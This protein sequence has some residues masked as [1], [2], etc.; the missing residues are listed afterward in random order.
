MKKNYLF[1]LVTLFL[2]LVGT[3]QSVVIT[4]YMDSPCPSQSGRTLEMY[5]DGTIDFTGWSVIRQSNGGGFSPGSTTIDISSL[6]SVTDGFVYLTNNSS[7]LDTEFG[8][9]AN[10]IVS[11]SINGNGDDGWQV[12]D[13]SDAIIDR[14]GVDGE[15][16][17]NTAWDHVDSYLYRKDG[18]APNAGS[19]DTNNWLYGGINL[20]DNKGLCN[21]DVALSTLVPLGSYSTTASTTPTIIVGSA[22]A[23]LDYFEANGPSAEKEMTI[24]GDNLTADITVTAPTNFEVS[25]TS[26]ASFASSVTLSQISGS[27]SSTTVYVRL[28]SGLSANTYSGDVTASSAGATDKTIAVSG[29]V[30]PADPQ[31]SFTA[32]LDQFN[33]IEGNGPS[34]E[35]DFTVEGLF[36]SS[37]LIVSA[38]AEF[39]VSL[40][41]GSGFSAA[42]S[43]T[44]SSGTVATTTV[45][46]R[47]KAGL[48]EANYT[49]DITL[50]STNV[51]DNT[52]AVEG[53]VFGPITNSIVITGVYDGS[54]SGGTPKGVELYVLK[55]VADLSVYGISSV[56]NGGGSTA[57]NVEFPL[58]AGAASAGTFIYISTED[59]NFN[60]FFGMMPDYTTGTVGIN[61]DDSIEL[62]ENG[63]IID[64][65]GDVDQ[66]GTGLDWDYLDGWAYRKSNTG[67]EGTTFTTTNWTY[68]GVDGLEGGTN[69]ATANTPFPIGTYANSTASVRNNSIDGFALYPNPVT[70]NNLTI[71]SNSAEVKN[72]SI[73][74]VLGKNVLSTSVSGNRA[75]INTALLSSG[76]YIIKVQEGLNT[77]TSKL[78]IK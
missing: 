56:S 30:S 17:S 29:E 77:A 8:I 71:T 69:N 57:G 75:E 61:G 2:T 28:A 59:T 37:D 44:P 9:T 51:T 7:T 10:V 48:S 3:A 14:L 4:G 64:V 42:V 16:A 15:D 62:Y 26:G 72:V 74:N 43:I 55:N 46:V 13:A 54:L 33:Y 67:P 52:I 31:F 53:K 78:V 36:L 32:F 73:F 20:L 39:E 63:Q 49:G 60:T 50:S 24:S 27:V 12:N 40:T 25:L 11:S 19:F 66:D 22:V 23:G 58:T 34:A 5:V 45:Y 1:T 68:S 38:P 65:F 76:I 35:Q 70:N 6:G 41:S 21:S 47:L 18:V